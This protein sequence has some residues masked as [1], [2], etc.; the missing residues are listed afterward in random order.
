MAEE[1][2]S[3]IKT[4]DVLIVSIPPDPDDGT[5]SA[6]QE[7]VLDAMQRYKVRGLLLDIS[8]VDSLDSFFA[9][10]IAETAQM[11]S[12]MGG[13]TVLVGMRPS[14]AITASQLG[15]TLGGAK[16]AL[17]VDLALDMLDRQPGDRS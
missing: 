14:I 1:R 10:T 11:I 16:S 9:R 13:Q 6:L 8:T 15:L 3:V 17:S 12:L 7:K 5:V 4:R 2:L